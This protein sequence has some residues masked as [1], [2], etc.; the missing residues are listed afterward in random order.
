MP[1]HTAPQFVF[2]PDEFQKMQ[3]RKKQ[4]LRLKTE[5]MERVKIAREMG[6]LSEN[7][8]YKYGKFELGNIRRE[9][10]RLHFLLEHGTVGTVEQH[11]EAIAFGC[12]F[13][14]QNEFGERTF[15]LVNEYESNP[16]ENKLSEKAR[17][18]RL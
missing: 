17:L 10:R 8:A 16:Q 2:T 13:T 1:H 11:Y 18:V 4:L 9:L 14:L 15:M 12:T 5:V 6:D 3:T 7:G